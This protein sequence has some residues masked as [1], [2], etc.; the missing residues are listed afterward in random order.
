MTEFTLQQTSSVE[1]VLLRELNHRINNDLASAISTVSLA[2]ARSNN[3]DVKIALSGVSDLLHHYADVH[4]AL[5]M[6]EDDAPI[7]AVEYLSQLCRSISLSKLEHRGIKLVL[8]ASPLWLQSDQCWRLGMIVYELITNAARHAFF[9]SGGEIRVELSLE[10]ES[11][12]CR[13]LDNGSAPENIQP[14]CGLKI[15]NVLTKALD[16]RF[17]QQF[18]AQGSTAA[19]AFPRNRGLNPLQL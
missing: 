13:V 12:E 7:D 8:S 16:G 17:E 10:G 9:K 11:V 4:H 15:V 14:G 1:Q 19:L 3:E 6:P 5:Q 18:G 2:A